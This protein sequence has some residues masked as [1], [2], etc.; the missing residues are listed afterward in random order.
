LQRA[1]FGLWGESVGL[2]PNPNDGRRLRYDKNL[3]RRDIRP[4]VERILNNI[5]S[6]LDEAGR[7]DERYGVKA[8]PPQGCEVSNSRGLDIFNGSFE[9]FKSRIRKHQKDTSAW[10]VT[11]WAIHDA[12]KF[13]GIID[14]LKGFAD[15]LEAITKS[16]GLLQEQHARLRHEIESI[17]DTESLRLLRDASS[18]DGASDH[19]VSETASRR[20]ITIAEPLIEGQTICSGSRLATTAES[21]VTARSGPSAMKESIDT[22]DLEIP[23][24]WPESMKLETHPQDRHRRPPMSRSLRVVAKPTSSCQG[25]LEEHYKCVV[26]DPSES[27]PRC[28]QTQ[29]QCSFLPGQLLADQDGTSTTPMLDSTSVSLSDSST[30]ALQDLPQHQRLINELI[31]RAK[32]RKP[33]SFAAGDAEYGK[34]LSGIKHEDENIW[35]ENSGK[36]VL[37]ADGGSSASKRMFLELRDIRSGKVPFVSAVPL[38]DSLDKVLASIEGPPETPYEG[39]VF[40]ITVKLPENDPYGPPLMRF[41]TKVYHPNISPQ[42]HICADYKEKWNSVISGFS[43]SPLNGQSAVWY[44]GNSKEAKWSLGALLTAMCGLLASPDVDDPLVPEIAMK[45]LEDYE[46]YCENA[47]YYTRKFATCGRPDIN[48]LL[49]L[50]DSQ[51]TVSNPMALEPEPSSSNFDSDIISLQESLRETYDDK[52]LFIPETMLRRAGSTSNSEPGCVDTT[53]ANVP[54]S[55]KDMLAFFWHQ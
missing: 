37:Q 31:G 9:R 29:R 42:G 54:S 51:T 2:I 4:G 47:R 8:D 35:L 39:G 40:W 19:D 50:E 15:G 28:V 3:D 34:L 22:D 48:D 41:H 43:R 30:S 26:I 44:R 24:A 1:R 23:G 12:D 27:C 46:E 16:L 18:R 49:F 25:C 32:P 10:T 52:A 5:K 38:D 20:L 33:L 17:S 11:R 53:Q 45:Y 14:R 13:E 6:L 55:V 36:I 7:V 21:F